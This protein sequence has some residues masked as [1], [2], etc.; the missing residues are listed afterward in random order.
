MSSTGPSA[1]TEENINNNGN[2]NGNSNGNNS[3]SGPDLMEFN[4]N[5]LNEENDEGQINLNY[6]EFLED[7][8]NSIDFFNKNF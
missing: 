1:I 5:L 8:V 6:L 3:K 4:N 7:R 2:N